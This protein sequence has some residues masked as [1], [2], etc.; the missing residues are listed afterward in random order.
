MNKEDKL[1][2]ELTEQ[3]KKQA[4]IIMDSFKPQLSAMIE[5]IMGRLYTD[6]S[7]YI[8][9]DHWTNYR[10][11]IIDGIAGYRSERGLGNHEF[12]QV[13]RAI[14]ESHRDDIIKDLN[15]DLVNENEML[16]QEIDRLNGVFQ[17]Y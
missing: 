11:H 9:S 14:Y 15:Q 17:R 8:E 2:P 12:K 4:Q 16:K 13:R 5:E 6:V 10:T 7:M 3:G 1:Y